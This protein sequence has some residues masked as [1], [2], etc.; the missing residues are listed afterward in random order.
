MSEGCVVFARSATGYLVIRNQSAIR[1]KRGSLTMEDGCS[2]E[3]LINSCPLIRTRCL[4]KFYLDKFRITISARHT[5][6]LVRKSRVPSKTLG[7]STLDSHSNVGNVQM[8]P[9]KVAAVAEN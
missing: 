4:Q 5:D 6:V 2:I 1:W 7:N 3:Y 8:R 9:H